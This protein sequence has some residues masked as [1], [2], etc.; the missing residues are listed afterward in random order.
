MHLNGTG[1]GSECSAIFSNSGTKA[2]SQ[3]N[4]RMPLPQDFPSLSTAIEATP[5]KIHELTPPLDSFEPGEV[6]EKKFSL[7]SAFSRVC[8]K[9]FF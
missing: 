9:G 7:V 1:Q 2:D 4:N 5:W 6:T 8:F 3:K